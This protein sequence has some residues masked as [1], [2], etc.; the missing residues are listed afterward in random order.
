MLPPEPERGKPPPPRGGEPALLP[1]SE[2]SLPPFLF[3]DEKMAMTDL[4]KDLRRGLVCCV[5]C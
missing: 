1:C 2:L 3:L 5:G 4:L